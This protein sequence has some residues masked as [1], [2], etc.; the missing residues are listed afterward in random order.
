MTY[1]FFSTAS[2]IEAFVRACVYSYRGPSCTNAPCSLEIQVGNS[3]ASIVLQKGL[4]CII[5]YYFD[6]NRLVLSRLFLSLALNARRRSD[7]LR[8][9]MAST[10]LASKL[11]FSIT[12]ALGL[13]LGFKLSEGSV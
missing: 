5:Y 10:P 6:I 1:P 7:G 9:A 4:I 3:R 13:G 12:G 8:V 2:Q 11:A